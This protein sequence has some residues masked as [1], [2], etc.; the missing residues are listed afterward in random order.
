MMGGDKLRGPYPGDVE[1]ISAPDSVDSLGNR[2]TAEGR[3]A[4]FPSNPQYQVGGTPLE[5]LA[6]ATSPDS[7]M[8]R[9]IKE[10]DQDGDDTA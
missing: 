6:P 5:Q 9:A 7:P 10:G 1:T 3:L 2:T 8:Q 4:Q